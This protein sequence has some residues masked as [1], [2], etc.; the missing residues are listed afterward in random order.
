[1]FTGLIEATGQVAAVQTT[2]DGSVLTIQSP[3]A[4][5][6]IQALGLGDSVAINGVCTTVVSVTSDGFTIEA[7]PE[8][9]SK[10]TFG[11]FAVGATVNLER[12]L[13]PTARLGGH[14]V[15]GHVD[16]LAT[17]QSIT[18]QG[19]STVFALALADPDLAKYLVPKGSVA[20][21]G[22]SLTVNTVADTT[23]ALTTGQSPTKGVVF[24]VAIIPYTWDHTTLSHLAVGDAVNIET[25]L[26]GKYVYRF[27]SQT[28]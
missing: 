23:V 5:E 24:T 27:Y 17:C 15:T 26:L 22:I 19:N 2:P 9:L 10:T 16:G 28:K 3:Q 7:S 14:F 12:P 11:Q 20:I 13:T 6:L 21:D 18:P 4:P 25:D 8:T 1:M